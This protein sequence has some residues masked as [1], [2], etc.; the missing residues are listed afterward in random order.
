MGQQ[1]HGV[2]DF[3]A[4]SSFESAANNPIYFAVPKAPVMT[5]IEDILVRARL[6]AAEKQ[7]PYAGA[8]LPKEAF[9]LLRQAPGATLVDV[10]TQAERYWV[11]RVPG[12]VAIEWTFYPGGARNPDFLAQLEATVQKTAAPVLFLCRSAHRSHH[13]AALAASAGYQNAFNVLEGFEG[14]RNAQ[15]HRNTVAGWRAAGLPWEQG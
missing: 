8:L 11:G 13:A 15:G 10:R 5:D 1:D 2:H 7:L 12:A 6:R 9:E 3:S 14:D 4:Q